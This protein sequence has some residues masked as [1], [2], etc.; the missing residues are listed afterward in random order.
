MSAPKVRDAYALDQ[1][2]LLTLLQGA[3]ENFP[4]LR[5]GR[6][7]VNQKEVNVPESAAFDRGAT[8]RDS[9][10][11]R[12]VDGSENLCR[13][14][15]VCARDGRCEEGGTGFPLILIVLRSVEVAVPCCEGV[16]DGGRGDFWGRLKDA[17]AEDRDR[18]T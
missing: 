6:G 7:R 12:V 1:P 5:T 18:V 16:G 2:V 15:E 9:L 3:P 10:V 17:K 8:R 11:E 13:V 4:P 14:K